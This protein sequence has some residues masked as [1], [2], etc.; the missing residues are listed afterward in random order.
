MH[1]EGCCQRIPCPALSPHWH[2]ALRRSAS[3]GKNSRGNKGVPLRFHMTA[4]LR[5]LLAML[6]LPAVLSSGTA[7]AVDPEL[8]KQLGSSEVSDKV[9]AIEALTRT[10][11]PVG[12]PILRALRD[13]NMAVTPSGQVIVLDGWRRQGCGDAAAARSA[14]DRIRK[15]G[16]QQSGARAARRCVLR[17]PAVLRFAR[18][19]AGCGQGAGILGSGFGRTDPGKG[20]R[21]GDRSHHQGRAGADSRPASTSRAP[22][23][24][25][26]WPR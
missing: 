3:R 26:A 7:L 1:A 15:R 21:H 22:I 19:A 2:G 5:V 4:A 17:V 6:L 20:S 10:A 24:R 16:G 25:C 18:R 9:R 14:A 13:G 11:D 8:V 12:L 23:R